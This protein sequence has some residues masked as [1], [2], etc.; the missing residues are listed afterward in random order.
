[1][2]ISKKN[3]LK[4]FNCYLGALKPQDNILILFD[5]DPDGLSAAIIVYRYLI[6]K[7]INKIQLE[8][9]SGI[10][11]LTDETIE[12]IKKLKVN[13]LIL[14]DLAF[15]KD[16]AQF[17]KAEKFCDILYIDHH[18]IINNINSEKTLMVQAQF[19]RPKMNPARYCTAKITFD[20]FR[21]KET[22]WLAYWGIIA[23]SASDNWMP[24]LLKARKKFKMSLA[25]AKEF[26]FKMGAIFLIMK[27]KEPG[28]KKFIDFYLNAKKPMYYKRGL[29]YYKAY[30][31]EFKK[32]L[33]AF[34]KKAMF[35]DNL[36]L[37]IYLIKS[38]WGVRNSLINE[39]SFANPNKTFV[40][41]EDDSTDIMKLS[42]R[43][44]DQKIKTNVLIANAVKGLDGSGGGHIPA[45]GGRIARK[46]VEKLIENIV[47]ESKPK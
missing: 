6:A 30:Q 38:K 27:S 29:K 1:M 31:A 35:F 22:A 26:F 23:D 3:V 42:L 40:V 28:M 5:D 17:K 33:K 19:L 10:K 36:D 20:L 34:H 16:V 43:R 44:Q 15:N 4:R 37:I 14:L 47:E 45:S 25:K 39:L 32:Y 21:V 24:F 2:N 9:N 18:S 12:K 46:D 11:R 41:I 13:K 7:K 8:M